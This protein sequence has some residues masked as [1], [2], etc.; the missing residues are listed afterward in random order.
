MALKAISTIA[1]NLRQW[2]APSRW[3][4]ADY[5]ELPDDGNLYRVLEWMLMKY[6]QE[7]IDYEGCFD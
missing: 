1:A 7:W 4:Y 6:F 3:T 2:P 5:L